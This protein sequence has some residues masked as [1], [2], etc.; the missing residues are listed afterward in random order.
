MLNFLTAIFNA[1]LKPVAAIL[2]SVGLI[3]APVPTEQIT[4]PEIL[5]AEQVE[6]I[7]PDPVAEELRQLRQ[8][9]SKLKAVNTKVTQVQSKAIEP[10]PVPAPVAAPH[11]KTFV[12]P[13]WSHS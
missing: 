5:P 6:E 12:T 11:I 3:T 4:T 2:V 8:E 1:I 10:L 7:K 9:L 13:Q